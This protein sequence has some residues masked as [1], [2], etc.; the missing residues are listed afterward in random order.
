MHQGHPLSSSGRQELDWQKTRGKETAPSRVC[1]S[2]CIPTPLLQ[3]QEG[4]WGSTALLTVEGE[5]LDPPSPVL[6]PLDS[7]LI[8]LSECW[9]VGR[10]AVARGC[11]R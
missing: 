10:A 6:P 3:L 9:V 5:G 1:V 11:A 8:P 4:S 2:K 7:F